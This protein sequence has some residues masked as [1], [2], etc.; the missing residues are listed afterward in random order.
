M[1]SVR[2]DPNG[3]PDDI[4]AQLFQAWVQ[5]G[6][7]DLN[8]TQSG[9]S[10]NADGRTLSFGSPT[11]ANFVLA[12]SGREFSI[13]CAD[14]IE[15]V[16]IQ[17]ILADAAEK[18]SAQEYGDATVYQ[19]QMT[20]R[21]FDLGSPMHFMRM[22]GDQVHIE[23][24]RRLS[25][26]VILDFEEGLVTNAPP[27]GLLF[28][29]PTRVDVTIFAP[30]PC[31]SALSAQ[32]AGSCTEVVAAT[33]ALAT[34]RPVDYDPPMFPAEAPD[35]AAAQQRRTDPTILGLARDSVSLDV[36]RDLLATG[37][38][39]SVLRMRGSLLAYHAALK[40]TVPDVAVMLL[41]SCIETLIAPTQE[42][43]KRKVTQRFIKALVQMCP[44][45]VGALVEHA[46]TEVAFNYRRRGNTAR[47]RAEL[48]DCI[49][50]SRSLPTHRGL[51]TSLA[52]IFVISGPDSMRVAL[53]SDL[54]R[55]AIIAF[56]QAPRSSVVGHP[57][58]E[59]TVE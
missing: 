5:V 4:A 44:E 50:G 43:G 24:S 12:R 32:V 16:V 33:C 52:S 22:L 11:G 57:P 38:M 36:F 59:G 41:V 1:V 55:K 9:S 47:R 58:I 49:Y 35:A 15:E 21:S 40:Q 6:A 27:G 26:V 20:V 48:L 42:W 29:P 31:H 10:A 51:R 14:G 23:G 19:T 54:A 2:V 7:A 13:Q 45:A 3:L 8:L 30:G 28:A 34:G 37:G 18:A 39:D 25:D 46:N 53:L 17:A 56:L